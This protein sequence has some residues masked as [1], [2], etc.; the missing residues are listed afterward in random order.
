MRIKYF[1]TFLR[2]KKCSGEMVKKLNL[3]QLFKNVLEEKISLTDQRSKAFHI[4]K[5]KFS[6]RNMAAENVVNYTK[7][8]SYNNLSTLAMF[9]AVRAAQGQ[10]QQQNMNV[11]VPYIR[12]NIPGINRDHVFIRT[13]QIHNQPQKLSLLI[14]PRYH[15]KLF[16]VIVF[17]NSKINYLPLRLAPP[18]LLMV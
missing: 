3:I 13:S 10:L 6:K 5:T 4:I 9:H 11:N 2:E 16:K 18:D 17:C 7:N 8:T 14:N 15:F 12:N 1:V